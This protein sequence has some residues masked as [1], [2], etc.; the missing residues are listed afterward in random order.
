MTGCMASARGNGELDCVV[1]AMA[2]GS[3]RRRQARRITSRSDHSWNS[4]RLSHSR[5]P[6]SSQRRW[7]RIRRSILP[8]ASGARGGHSAAHCRRPPA[9]AS[10]S[11]PPPPRAPVTRRRPSPPSVPS[12]PMPRISAI[13][14]AS[15]GRERAI[16]GPLPQR[17]SAQAEARQAQSALA[18]ASLRQILSA[19]PRSLRCACVAH[20]PRSSARPAAHPRSAAPT[21]GASTR[22]TRSQHACAGARPPRTPATV[23]TTDRIGDQEGIRVEALRADAADHP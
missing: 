6:G 19:A 10:R 17:D 3:A 12:A 21:A 2:L 7:S 1:M 20:A 23:A 22:R 18:L 15:T 9:L 13:K 14:S 16:A 5:K 11:R 8:F 4:S